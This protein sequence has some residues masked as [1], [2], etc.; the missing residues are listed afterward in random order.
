MEK[1]AVNPSYEKVVDLRGKLRTVWAVYECIVK[2]DLRAR[3]FV[4]RFV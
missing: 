1:Y 3:T 4:R 2:R